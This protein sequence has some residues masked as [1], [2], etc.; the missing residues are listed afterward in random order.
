MGA[1]AHRGEQH[2]DAAAYDT[3]GYVLLTLRECVRGVAESDEAI[4]VARSV[5]GGEDRRD[6]SVNVAV[7]AEYMMRAWTQYDATRAKGNCTI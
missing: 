5:N 2:C 7:V 4:Y 3:Q 1:T 6:R